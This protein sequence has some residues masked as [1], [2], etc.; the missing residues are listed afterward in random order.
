MTDFK[1]PLFVVKMGNDFL[2]LP[3]EFTIVD[4]VPDSIRKG[5]GM[6]DALMKT[7]LS[8]KERMDRIQQMF[9]TLKDQKSI[10]SWGLQL[11]S[12]PTNVQCTVL[13]AA[14]IFSDKNVI[15]INE[16]V[17]RKLPIQKA[18]DLTKDD[19]V[20]VYQEAK[21]G[22]RRNFEIADKVFRTLRDSCGMLKIKV[23]EPH[24][25][26]LQKEDDAGELEKALLNYMMRDR[27]GG[28]RHPKI[29]MCIL[30]RESN[31]KMVKEVCAMYQ[32]PS[33]VITCRN[34]R[35]FNMSKA[36]NILRQVNSKIGGDLY[37]MKFPDAMG[38]KRTMLIG[39]DVCHAGPTSVVGFSA[40]TNKE[41]T[42]Y[43]SQYL[44]QK[45][46]QEIVDA[47][48]KETL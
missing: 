10:K 44:V 25:I 12:V 40:S 32:I 11:E 15:H 23:E 41:M 5:P 20:I 19:W 18:V 2:Y 37:Q 16:Q 43:Y 42:Q 48:L 8:P 45:R 28:F 39:I 3:P 29:A 35:S 27:D 14:Q 33:Q 47:R 26:E 46:G 4:G 22:G 30:D 17:L 6:R 13:G 1:Q 34:G 36:S 21:H 31:Y 9:D 7:K 24:F 38:A